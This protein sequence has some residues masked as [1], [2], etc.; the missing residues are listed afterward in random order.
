MIREIMHL[1][2]PSIGKPVMY[3]L[4]DVYVE[5]PGRS[6]AGKTPHFWMNLTATMRKAAR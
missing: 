3:T 2:K 4:A 1:E 6:P 5:V